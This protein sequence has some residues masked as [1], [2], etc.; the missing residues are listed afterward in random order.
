MRR[1]RTRV[2]RDARVVCVVVGP[3]WGFCISCVPVAYDLLKDCA[4]EGLAGASA[5]EEE[6]CGRGDD[7]GGVGLVDAGVYEAQSLV[8]INLTEGRKGAPN[9]PSKLY[10]FPSS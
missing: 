8:P 9:L 1:W 3:V 5:V 6:V 4:A 2:V 10:H 7:V